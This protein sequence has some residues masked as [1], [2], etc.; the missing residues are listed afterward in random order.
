MKKLRLAIVGVP[1]VARAAVAQEWVHEAA[2]FGYVRALLQ[3]SDVQWYSVS[4][5]VDGCRVD[6]PLVETALRRSPSSVRLGSL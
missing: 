1:W 5:L 3:R 6:I 4:N 2:R